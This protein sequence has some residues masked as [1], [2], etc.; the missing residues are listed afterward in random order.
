MLIIPKISSAQEGNRVGGKGD[1]KSTFEKGELS[2]TRNKKEYKVNP[3]FNGVE[4]DKRVAKYYSEEDLNEMDAKKLKQLNYM[5]L[6]SFEVV[7]YDNLSDG[8]KKYIADKFDTG[9]YE[10]YRKLNDKVVVE[11]NRDGF[12][13]KISLLSIEEL[14]ANRNK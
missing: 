14:I 13:F 11:I 8:C 6:K 2:L 4:I 12:S 9:E 5:Y 1:V 3:V 10:K 7:D